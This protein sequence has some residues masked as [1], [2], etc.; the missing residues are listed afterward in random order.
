LFL[1]GRSRYLAPP[2]RLKVVSITRQ[3]IGWIISLLNGR[4]HSFLGAR[5]RADELSKIIKLD[6]F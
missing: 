5:L 4:Y 1:H 3:V 6:L 2:R